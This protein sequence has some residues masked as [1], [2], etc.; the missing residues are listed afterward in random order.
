MDKKYEY[1]HRTV[2]CKNQD[3]VDDVINNEIY[4]YNKPED[5]ISINITPYINPDK[6][7]GLPVP[8]YFYV[9]YVYRC[10]IN[11]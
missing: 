2:F 3:D 8:I 10:E 6:T 1:G 5:V 11:E 4:K 9:S 7:D